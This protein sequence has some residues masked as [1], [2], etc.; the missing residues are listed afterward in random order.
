M[1]RAASADV[2]IAFTNLGDVV[3]P[4]VLAGDPTTR[5]GGYAVRLAYDWTPMS[6]PPSGMPSRRADL[7]QPVHP[8]ETMTLIVPLEAPNQ[9]GDYRLTF[10]L[11]QELVAWFG[12]KG[13]PMLVVPVTV[14]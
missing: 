8:G 4:D 12:A 11:V 1:A 2:R 5:D 3:W 14:K 6:T 9:P 10:V 13:A 7:P